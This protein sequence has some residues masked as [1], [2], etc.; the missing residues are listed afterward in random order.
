MFANLS[1]GRPARGA[2]REGPL[3]QLKGMTATLSYHL[4]PQPLCKAVLPSPGT[5]QTP[6]DETAG[7]AEGLGC[8]GHHHFLPPFLP[9]QAHSFLHPGP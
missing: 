9:T 8:D 1:G 4:S 2:P 6:V 5:Q 7:P 3:P